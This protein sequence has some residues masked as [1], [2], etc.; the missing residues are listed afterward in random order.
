MRSGR[1][2]DVSELSSGN[3]AD[4]EAEA[5]AGNWE[6]AQGCGIGIRGWEEKGL[7]MDGKA[8][9]YR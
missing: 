4:V 3:G 2:T 5:G 6:G 8:R 7:R 1:V 9:G